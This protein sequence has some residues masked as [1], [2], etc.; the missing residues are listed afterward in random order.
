MNNLIFITGL[1]FLIYFSY[2][3][4]KYSEVENKPII[5][6]MIVGIIL[7]IISNKLLIVLPFCLFWFFLSYLLWRLKSLGGADVKILSILPIFYLIDSSNIFYSQLIFLIFFGI[8]GTIYGLISKQFNNK[9]IVP[10]IPLITLTFI[11]FRV[12][13]F[14]G[15]KN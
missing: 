4:L 13:F 7:S 14:L 3:D 6:F 2:K 1:L 11:L 12:F 5:V 15:T 10:F 9:N 8:M